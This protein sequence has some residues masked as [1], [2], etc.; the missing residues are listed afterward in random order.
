MVAKETS[1][2]GKMEF[3]GNR[4]GHRSETARLHIPKE[5]EDV[6]LFLNQ[7]IAG[8]RTRVQKPVFDPKENHTN[9]YVQAMADEIHAE[10]HQS[11]ADIEN[12]LYFLGDN[13]YSP[14]LKHFQ[15]LLAECEQSIAFRKEDK[16]GF[17]EDIG[18][19]TIEELE[20]ERLRLVSIRERLRESVGEG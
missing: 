16:E 2:S 19:V 15:E 5:L 13:N 1:E 10:N 8:A 20:K 18:S 4:A 3:V 7:Q 6:A 12:L 11:L 17:F 9:P 14:V